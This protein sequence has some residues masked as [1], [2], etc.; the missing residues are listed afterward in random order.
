MYV[1]CRVTV[2]LGAVMGPVVGD[3]S[4]WDLWCYKLALEQGEMSA[5]CK[6][7]VANVCMY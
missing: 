1:Y 5:K 2:R 7:L 4:L 3:W 6:V